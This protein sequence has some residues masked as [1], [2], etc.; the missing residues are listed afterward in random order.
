MNW[1]KRSDKKGTGYVAYLFVELKLIFG[2]QV[3]L[4][5]LYIAAAMTPGIEFSIW[6]LYVKRH[7]S[8]F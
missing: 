6:E 8:V 4:T 1:Y 3:S 7:R 2:I 5:D